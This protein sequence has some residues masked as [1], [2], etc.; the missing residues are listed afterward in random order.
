MTCVVNVKELLG[1]K[2]ILPQ[3]I[4][5]LKSTLTREKLN[6]DSF[7]YFKTN[8]EL[9]ESFEN[10]FGQIFNGQD[11]DHS[12]ITEHLQIL[13]KKLKTNNNSLHQNITSTYQHTNTHNAML[14][15]C[16]QIECKLLSIVDML[17]S[18][19][20]CIASKSEEESLDI[21]EKLK[22]PKYRNAQSDTI[23]N[24]KKVRELLMYV[25]F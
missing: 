17:I 25:A 1:I 6:A 20:E 12:G 24:L 18:D 11:V 14:K 7:T 21:L 22:E 19:F 5:V 8:L 2:V 4:D 9:W 15:E 10:T 23:L 3:L 13:R 16:S